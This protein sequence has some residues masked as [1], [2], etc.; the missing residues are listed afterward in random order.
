MNASKNKESSNSHF[1]INQLPNFPFSSPSFSWEP[2]KTHQ[3][4]KKTKVPTQQTRTRKILSR[5][6]E[7]EDD[8]WGEAWSPD[9]GPPSSQVLRPPCTF[10]ARRVLKRAQTTRTTTTTSP[11]LRLIL[12]FATASSVIFRS[13]YRFLISM[14]CSAGN[15]VD[16]GPNFEQIIVFVDTQF[17]QVFLLGGFWIL[18]SVRLFLLVFSWIDVVFRFCH[19]WLPI[20]QFNSV[21]SVE[22][23]KLE[24]NNTKCVWVSLRKWCSLAKIPDCNFFGFFMGSLGFDSRLPFSSLELNCKKMMCDSVKKSTSTDAFRRWSGCIL[25]TKHQPFKPRNQQDHLTTVGS[26]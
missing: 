15:F 12:N 3:Q 5:S 19:P 2:N 26:K 8:L 4:T 25:S 11:S 13:L 9:S 1:N 22:L 21:Y 20:S 10:L 7:R 14:S 17:L 16:F 23:L 6:D 24:S 18:D